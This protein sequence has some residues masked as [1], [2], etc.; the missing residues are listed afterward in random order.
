MNGTTRSQVKK[1]THVRIVTRVNRG[2]GK[3]TEG[4][5]RQVFTHPTVHAHGIKVRRVGEAVGREREM[6]FGVTN[7]AELNLQG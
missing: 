3:P 5:V 7:A 2:S 6:I 1:G 4:V